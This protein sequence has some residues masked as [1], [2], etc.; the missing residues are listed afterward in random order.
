MAADADL[1]RA[2]IGVAMGLTAVGILIAV[3]ITVEAPL[4]G[5]SMNPARSF[6]SALPAGPWTGA[7]LYFTAPVLGMLAAV[8]GYRTLRGSTSWMCAK[9]YHPAD[10][11]CIHCGQGLPGIREDQR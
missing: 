5:M 8:K 11:P 9:L 2:L 4:S 3:D 7:R 10:K 6:A 1:R